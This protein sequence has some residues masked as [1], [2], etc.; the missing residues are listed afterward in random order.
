MT[1]SIFHDFPWLAKIPWLSIT[2]GTMSNV[3]KGL[4]LRTILGKSEWAKMDTFG[5]WGTWPPPW[6]S[7]STTTDGK[8]KTILKTASHGQQRINVKSFPSHKTHRAALISFLEPSARHQFT[9]PDHRYGT[10]ASCLFTSQLSLVLIVPTHEGMARL[11]WPGKGNKKHHNSG[12]SRSAALWVK[13][14]E[15]N[16]LTG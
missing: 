16:Y 2:V 7:S 1:L 3:P 9:L 8:K 13:K 4:V 12:W 6:S 15:E 10:S 11:S 5:M 14:E